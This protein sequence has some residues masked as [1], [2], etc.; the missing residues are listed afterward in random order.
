MVIL[1]LSR[2]EMTEA[3]GPVAPEKV[4]RRRERLGHE[5][6]EMLDVETRFL[7]FPDT[8][9]DATPDAATRVARVVAE[10]GPDAVLT[11]G[12]AWV[13]GPR[14][15]DHQATGRIA[16]DAITLARIAK[17]VDPEDP[18]RAPCPFFTYRGLHS[19][20]P[21]VTVDVEEQ[22]ERIFELAAFYREAIG[23]G[24]REWLDARLRAAG[25]SEGL[26]YAEAFDAWETGGGLV[27]TL[28]PAREGG[29]L[30]HPDRDE[31]GV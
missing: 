30:F 31:R 26:R 19:R 14:H 24:D 22:A 25:E 21:K 4:A 17:V 18:H 23:F 8:R 2:G 9:I 28:L 1:W 15:P 29:A 27:E 5:A 13:R 6:G 10:I 3:F 7:D 11:W 12:E 16:R 20:L